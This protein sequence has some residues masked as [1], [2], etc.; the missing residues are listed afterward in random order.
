MPTSLLLRKKKRYENHTQNDLNQNDEKST[1]ID[2][3]M[4][5]GKTI[6]SIPFRKLPSEGDP[7][8]EEEEDENRQIGMEARSKKFTPQIEKKP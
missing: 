6:R 5:Q 2:D 4:S 7:D 8:G 1:V 3:H